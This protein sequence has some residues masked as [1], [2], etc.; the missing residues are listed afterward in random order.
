M[1]TKIFLSLI[2]LP[3]CLLGPCYSPESP[4]KPGVDRYIT[5]RIKGT[6]TGS[7]NN[8]PLIADVDFIGGM[9]KFASAKSNAEGQ[10]TIE[11]EVFWYHEW[12]TTG[13]CLEVE[14]P[15]YKYGVSNVRFTEEWQT[16][17]VKLE[18][19]PKGLR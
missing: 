9:K 19:E 1:K 16:I 15:G 18:L 10:Y 5:F 8:S 11:Q 14:A 4:K 3:L 13:L 12:P 6:I 17:D 2:V 7:I